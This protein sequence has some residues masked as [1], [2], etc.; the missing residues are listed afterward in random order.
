[1]KIKSI[2]III[3]VLIGI[4]TIYCFINYSSK[5]YDLLNIENQVPENIF[6][7]K[8]HNSLKV[9]S[10]FCYENDTL[11]NLMLNNYRI[12]VWKLSRYQGL[13]SN[14][15]DLCFSNDR[16]R[17]FYFTLSSEIEISPVLEIIY[18][19]PDYLT[20]NITLIQITKRV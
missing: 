16:N 5:S 1:M 8:Y 15:I 18:K 4:L 2:R 19:I 20:E 9:N 17:D 14:N 3:V 11:Y 6:N 7:F 10:A 13:S 12:I